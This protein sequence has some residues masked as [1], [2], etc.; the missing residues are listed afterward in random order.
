LY[1]QQ[2]PLPAPTG[3]YAVGRTQFDWTDKSRVDLENENGHREII[4]WVWYPASPQSG[5]QQAEWLPGA[6]GEMFSGWQT[7]LRKLTAPARSTVLEPQ[8]ASAAVNTIRT[9]AYADAPV[10][11]NPGKYP[12]LLFSPGWGVLP[13]AYANLIEE[14]VSHGYIVAGIV[15]TYY[16]PFVVFADG[17]VAGQHEFARDLPGSPRPPSGSGDIP[18]PVFRILTG[19]LRFALNQLEQVNADAKNPLKGR[20]DFDH[21]GVFGHSIG[22]T[23]AVEVAK[24]DAR[25][26]AAIMLDG[27]VTKG[28]SR[29][30]LVPKPLLL[31]QAGLVNGRAQV[32]GESGRSP[33]MS[34]L[35]RGGKPSYV[36]TIAGTTHGSFDDLKLMPFTNRRSDSIDPARA[37]AVTKAYVKAFF[38]QHLMGKM[39]SLLSGASPDYPEATVERTAGPQ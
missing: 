20:L 26:R 23:V 7:R 36:V 13:M 30:P 9:H 28:I 19:D 11:P 25:V 32:L 27:G 15:H 12:V 16:S 24:D 29:D 3:Q 31:I 10:A 33:P 39:S 14:T 2:S 4:V 38:S 1:A 35:L 6:W 17:R 37:L 18:E 34:A 21:V 22:A 5:A 8:N